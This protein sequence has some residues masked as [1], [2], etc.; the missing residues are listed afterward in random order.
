MIPA[1]HVLT[2]QS[3]PCIFHCTDEH[4]K[5][6]VH[7]SCASDIAVRRCKLQNTLS[8]AA[9]RILAL[10]RPRESIKCNGIGF[11]L[12][13]EPNRGQLLLYSRPQIIYGLQS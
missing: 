4:L 8:A 7:W 9:T 2:G 6:S 13:I 11:E 1:G 3:I 10:S 5:Q 12:G